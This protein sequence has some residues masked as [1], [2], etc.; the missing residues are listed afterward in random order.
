MSDRSRSTARTSA[1]PSKSSGA[2]SRSTF[3]LLWRAR[4]LF[5]QWVHR[6]FIVRYQ[7]SLLGLAWAVLQPALLLVIYGL[8]FTKVLHVHSPRGSYLVFAYCG[9]APWT[10]LANAV[11]WGLQCLLTN[12]SVI[13]QVYFP[14][15][16]V[17]LAA[18]GVIVVDLL[19]GTAVLLILQVATAGTIHLSTITL[20]PIYVGLLLLTEAIVIFSALLGSFIRDVRFVVPLI[21]QVGFIATPIMYPQSQV[22]SQLGR[23]AFSLNPLAR[24]IGGIRQA[25]VFGQW[26]SVTLILSLLVGGFVLLVVAVLYSASVEERLP[27]LL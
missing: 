18:G 14:R 20:V 21:L 2:P 7:Q 11:T 8:V 4:W 25:V 1:A 27:D 15:S 26:P 19:I 17:P 22:K 12:T 9:L 3:P 5:V 16:V 23:L 10:F 24:V 13:K 6:D